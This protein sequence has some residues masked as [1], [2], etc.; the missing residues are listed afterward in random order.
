MPDD[1][2]AKKKE[3][4]E[5]ARRLKETVRRLVADR[6]YQTQAAL[7]SKLGVKENKLSMLICGR[8]VITDEFLATFERVTGMR[9]T[10]EAVSNQTLVPPAPDAPKKLTP[11]GQIMKL[12]EAANNLDHDAENLLYDLINFRTGG[13][14][15]SSGRFLKAVQDITLLKDVLSNG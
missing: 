8:A 3:L 6:K 15:L 7:A 9:V 13:E 5:L 12:V 1:H 10:E 2:K 11:F 4:P 14:Q